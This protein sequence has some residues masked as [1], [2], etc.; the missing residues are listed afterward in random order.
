M[1]YQSINKKLSKYIHNKDFLL[2]LSQSQSE[3]LSKEV[4]KSFREEVLNIP[5]IDVLLTNPEFSKWV[6]MVRTKYKIEKPPQNEWVDSDYYEERY[7]EAI[8]DLHFMLEENF[9][10]LGI[11]ARGPILTYIVED[12]IDATGIREIATG[13]LISFRSKEV[14]SITNTQ[15]LS[16]TYQV[17]QNCPTTLLGLTTNQRDKL[18]KELD[19][20]MDFFN[21]KKIID[22]KI[23][24]RRYFL[25][26]LKKKLLLNTDEIKQWFKES[27]VSY[28]GTDEEHF[29]EEISYLTKTFS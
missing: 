27:E 25:Y 2:N 22:Y 19:L 7:P 16:I 6:K 12:E 8:R 3:D 4:R 14:D 13:K 24:G 10:K 5:F 26:I 29:S 17:D 18:I 15:Y 11:L 9:P 1:N 21:V 28:L 23:V 20:P